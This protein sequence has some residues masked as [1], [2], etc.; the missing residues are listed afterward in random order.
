MGIGCRILLIDENDSFHRIPM[1]RLERLLHF[2]R[3]ESLPHFG[4]KRVR[5]ARVFLEVAGRQVLSIRNVDYFLLP[6]D[7]KGRINK[8][9]WEKGMRLG[10]DLLPP[11]FNEENPK[12][13]INASHRFAK[14]RYEHEFKWKPSRKVEEAIVHSV[15]SGS[16]VS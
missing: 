10:M 6:F 11:L 2:D 5:F 12:Q 16:H 13:V 8:R 7:A 14:R 1:S 9:E 3:G 15:F 4:G